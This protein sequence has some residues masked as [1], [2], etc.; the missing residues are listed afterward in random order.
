[1]GG[2]VMQVTGGKLLNTS[3]YAPG[4]GLV[5]QEAMTQFLLA[6]PNRPELKAE[7]VFNQAQQLTKIEGLESGKEA[8]KTVGAK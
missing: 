1:M 3:W 8:K 2:V 7:I 5:K 6:A 4:V